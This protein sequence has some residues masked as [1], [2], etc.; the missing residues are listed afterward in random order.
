VDTEA[1]I[2]VPVRSKRRE[3]G[4]EVDASGADDSSIQA[5]LGSRNGA[6]GKKRR[7]MYSDVPSSGS[8]SI[9]SPTRSAVDVSVVPEDPGSLEESSFPFHCPKEV[10]ELSEMSGGG[11]RARGFRRG[12][13]GADS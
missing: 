2:G 9:G 13:A 5:R 6:F 8:V 12:D 11:G 1:G 7:R 3:D 10:M 4:V